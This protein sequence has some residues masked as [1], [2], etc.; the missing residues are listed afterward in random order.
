MPPI[1]E[2]V[3]VVT[4]FAYSNDR[5]A[6]V[7]RSERVGT[8]RG[9]WSAF[10]GYV[11][12]IPLNQAYLELAEEADVTPERVRLQGIG[13]PLP[14][15]DEETGHRWLVFPFLF[16]L[17]DGVEIRTD[18]EAAEWGW[19]APEEIADLQ[20]VPGLD[21]ALERVWPPFGD[22]EFW[23]G[24]SSVATNT[25]V[26]AAELARRGLVALG[27]FVQ[28]NYD[29]L[30]RR[31]L[32]RAVRAF[33]ACR[34]VMGV[35]PDL[36]AR[37]LLAIEREGGQFK[38][39][40]L[41][42]ELLGTVQDATDLS[43]GVAAEELRRKKRLFTLSYSQAVR[44]AIVAWHTSEGEVVVAESG[45]R[46]EGLRLAEHL[47][48]HGVRVRAVPDSEIASVVREVDAV[49]VGCDAITDTDELLNKVGT[50]QAVVVANAADVLAYAVAQTFKITPP[51][52]PV[53]LERQAPADYSP[54][55]E[56]V[57][58]PSVFDLTPLDGFAEVFTEDGP[59]TAGRLAGTRSELASVELIPMA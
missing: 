28:A 34:P 38:F 40:A 22:R 33:A 6:L 21:K 49:L 56:E 32:L 12:R 5:I 26:G 19:F 46:N 52:W 47:S 43:A 11:E 51:G 31:G 35:F 45:P 7:R 2:R 4:G 10:S 44:D 13:I 20:T 17:A 18:W 54:R 58:G 48:R 57:V 16:E 39:D 37:L 50:R 55:S 59:L 15:D 30:D 24:L 53:F 27:G 3:P 14:V 42:T 9:A 25:S 36:A 41:V 8:Y 1:R 29:N 23:D